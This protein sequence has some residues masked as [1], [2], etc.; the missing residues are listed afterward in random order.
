MRD[1]AVAKTKKGAGKRGN[2]RN[3]AMRR[4]LAALAIG[5]TLF[6]TSNLW[7]PQSGDLVG[8]TPY[9][10]KISNEDYSFYLTQFVYSEKDGVI[11]VIIE[12]ENRDV[13]EKRLEYSA[14]ERTSGSLDVE[15]AQEAPNYAVLRISGMG[16]RWKEISL[17][18]GEEGNDTQVKFYANIDAVD[19]VA[20]L[21][22]LSTEG[23]LAV[24][25]KAQIAYDDAQIREKNGQI[26]V[27]QEENQRIDERIKALM[28]ET[29]LTEE[30]AKEAEGLISKARSRKAA[31]EGTVAD[32]EDEIAELQ[33]RTQ[34]IEE[35]IKAV[36]E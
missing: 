35:Q 4:F 34:K 15:T 36:T 25:L 17:R 18:I 33:E 11:Q 10:K 22:K 30:E 2:G 13:Q 29:Y 9:Y 32:R 1:K 24:R 7:V 19:R 16:P 12:I 21:P 3:S 14:I 28:G 8:A 27:L 31:N 20:S 23:Y 5:Y 6:L 26:K